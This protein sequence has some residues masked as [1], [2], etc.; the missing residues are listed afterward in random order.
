MLET[1]TSR[2]TQAR[3]AEWRRRYRWY[4]ARWAED[5]LRCLRCREAGV[6]PLSS[7][8]LAG[9]ARRLSPMATGRGGKPTG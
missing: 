6:G 4:L 9:P 3:L 7:G 8:R 2:A 5:Y 1:P